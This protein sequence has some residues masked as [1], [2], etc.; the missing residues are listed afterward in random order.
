M[1]III[2]KVHQTSA[3]RPDLEI[4]NKKKKKKRTCRIV[5][6]AVPTDPR[7]KLKESEKK[8]KYQGLE[9]ELKNY[10][11]WKWRWCR[12]WLARSVRSPKDSTGIR[13]FG[14]MTTSRDHPNHSIVDIGQNTKSPGELRRFAVTQTPVRNHQLMLMRRTLKSVK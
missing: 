6:F 3:R 5:G 14:N 8:D 7:A 10:G 11:T 9:R 2:Q 4:V 12:L 1:I 13:N